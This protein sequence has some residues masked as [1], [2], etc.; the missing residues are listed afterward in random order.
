MIISEIQYPKIKNSFH[1]CN[2]WFYNNGFV[3]FQNRFSW[4]RGH[5]KLFF[6]TT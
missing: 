4:Q 3:V 6:I 1:S 2:S 5:P